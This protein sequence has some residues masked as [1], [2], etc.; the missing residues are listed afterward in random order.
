MGSL[1]E[2]HNN[3]SSIVNDSSGGLN[4]SDGYSFAKGEHYFYKTNDSNFRDPENISNNPKIDLYFNLVDVVNHSQMH[5]FSIT[6]INNAKLNIE[7]YLGDLEQRNGPEIKYANHFEVEYFFQRE[8]I[9]IIE[10][11]INGV[12]TG[13]KKTLTLSNIITNPSESIIFFEGIGKLIITYKKR[14]ENDLNLISL[15]QFTFNLSNHIFDNQMSMQGSFFIIYINDNYGNRALYKS[16]EFYNKKIISHIIDIPNDILMVNNNPNTS[17]YIVLF[18]PNLN[19]KKQVGFA[20]FNLNLMDNNKRYD[21]LT[22][23]NLESNKYGILGNIQINYDQKEKLTFI[24]YLAKGMRINLDIA[25]DYT[26]SNN[27]DNEVP[28]HNTDPRYPND[29]EKAIESCGSIVAFYDYDQLFPV[30]GFGGKPLYSNEVSHC[31]NINFQ[32]DP[33]IKGINNI[34]LAYRQSLSKITLDGPTCFS[35]VIEKVIQEINYDMQHNRD[36]NHYYILLILTDGCINDSQQ[37]RDKIVEASSLPLSIIIVGIGKADF[38]LMD[39]LDGDKEP[40]K[41][42]RGEPW[43]RDIVQFV[44]FEK[45]KRTN[46]INYGTDL[47]EEVLKEIPKQVEEYYQKIGRFYESNL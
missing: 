30:Y 43:K 23:I 41:N 28:L 29:Y 10:H 47:T 12:S 7:T 8:Q 46:A 15:F 44:E 34:I 25:I 5:S 39:L 1:C 26:L 24:D 18:C 2:S 42:S 22:N 45:F 37:T 20:Q 17:L 13:I 35:Y 19:N 6:I 3:K 32:Q 14:T 38:T 21:Q 31:F 40:V 16:Q 11:N 36:E 4:F 9:L 27:L 33:N